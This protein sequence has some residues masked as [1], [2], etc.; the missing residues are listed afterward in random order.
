MRERA[1]KK[2]LIASVAEAWQ[3]SSHVHR[4]NDVRHRSDACAVATI[5]AHDTADLVAAGRAA[6]LVSEAGRAARVVAFANL[7]TE[8]THRGVSI[9][10]RRTAA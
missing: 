1:T 9:R 4:E 5:P 3:C 2:D 8:A 10:R 7:G 6:Y